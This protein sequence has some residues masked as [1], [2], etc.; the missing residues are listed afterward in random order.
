MDHNNIKSLFCTEG[1]WN[2]QLPKHLKK[3]K[4]DIEEITESVRDESRLVGKIQFLKIKH[5]EQL[6]G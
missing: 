4:T 3:K 2:N 1:L 5:L 6:Q